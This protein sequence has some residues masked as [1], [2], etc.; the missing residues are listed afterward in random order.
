MALTA[1][2]LVRPHHEEFLL[3]RDQYHVFADHVSECALGEKLV[4]E[5]V[6][7]GDLGVVPGCE[8]VDR[9]ELLVRVEGEVFR[10]VV[11]EVQ[12]VRAVADDEDL[13]EA[14]QRPGVSV[15]GVVLVFDDLLH[16]PPG[17]D[18]E[19]LEFDLDRGDAVDQEDD[20]VAVVAVV[21]VDA[22][23]VD[24]FE[25]VL[26]PVLDVDEGVVQ[27][28]AV[29]AGERFPA[30]EGTRGLVHV[31]RDDLVEEPL[32]FAVGQRDAIQRF[33]LLPE[34]RFKRGPVTYVGAGYS[35]FRSRSFATKA[36]SRSRSLSYFFSIHLALDWPL[37]P[38]GLPWPIF[39]L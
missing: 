9:Q 35:Y 30:P 3:A 29:V 18:A 6:E 38:L 19:C 11:G 25:G 17:A 10:V 37:S 2:D 5:V 4:G 20:V 31:R 21:G 1:V 7:V 16:R 26:A 15:A 33:E 14:K 32:E 27:R 23:L 8:P 24:D 13:H 12:R 22:E 36:S 34:V 28:R 39:R